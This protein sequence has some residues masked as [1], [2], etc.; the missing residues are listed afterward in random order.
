MRT[1]RWLKPTTADGRVLFSTEGD[2]SDTPGTTSSTLGM[3]R[4]S[5]LPDMIPW[6]IEAFDWRRSLDSD[7]RGNVTSIVLWTRNK[8]VA[9]RNPQEIIKRRSFSFMVPVPEGFHRGTLTTQ[10]VIPDSA[11][12]IMTPSFF[13]FRSDLQ[14]KNVVNSNLCFVERT[15]KHKSNSVNII[16]YSFVHSCLM[17]K[18]TLSR[19]CIS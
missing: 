3:S 19:L 17:I 10:K 16:I 18:A 8:Q 1:T 13:R 4:S 14:G 6:T 5:A 9:N 2:S 11:S 15:E 12:P 7:S